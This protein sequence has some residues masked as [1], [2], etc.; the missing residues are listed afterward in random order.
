M[1]ST[2][3]TK[4]DVEEARGGLQL[5]KSRMSGFGQKRGLSNSQSTNRGD[6]RLDDGGARGMPYN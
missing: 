6:P 3:Y 4:Q 5:L 1:R 2:A